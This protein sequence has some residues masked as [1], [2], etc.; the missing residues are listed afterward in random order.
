[1]ARITIE[2][3]LKH[4]PNRFELV[5]VAARRARE[6]LA[7]GTQLVEKSKDD[8]AIVVA[9]RE[10][11]AG[12]INQDI[13][14]QNDSGSTNYDAV[15]SALADKAEH[16]ELSNNFDEE[17]EEATDATN[18]DTTGN[19]LEKDMKSAKPIA[20]AHNPTEEVSQTAKDVSEDTSTVADKTDHAN[21]NDASG[22]NAQQN[23]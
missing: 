2:K 8:C 15:F 20:E 13:L 16:V 17:D 10:I 4:I 23:I 18:A 9:L 7:G 22:D 5:H 12:R 11:E 6:L 1:M 19:T 3:C 14:D 21:E